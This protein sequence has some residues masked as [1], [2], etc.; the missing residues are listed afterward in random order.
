MTGSEAVAVAMLAG[1][2]GAGVATGIE[3][4]RGLLGP[5]GAAVSLVEMWAIAGAGGSRVL[6]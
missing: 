4:A 5:G 2:L 3:L 6:G 1:V